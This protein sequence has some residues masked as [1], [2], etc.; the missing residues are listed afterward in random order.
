MLYLEVVLEPVF[1]IDLVFGLNKY[2]G[3][4]A[5]PKEICSYTFTCAIQN[6]AHTLAI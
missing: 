6:L 5:K 1:G 2:K 3:L 4:K